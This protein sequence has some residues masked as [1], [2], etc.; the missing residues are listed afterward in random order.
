MEARATSVH[1]SEWQAGELTAA[2]AGR[3]KVG[4]QTDGQSEGGGGK[5]GAEEAGWPIWKQNHTR[6]RPAFGKATG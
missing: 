6:E 5:R 1:L 3:L 2:E 4:L